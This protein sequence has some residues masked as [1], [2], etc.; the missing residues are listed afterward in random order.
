MRVNQK[1][2]W[3]QILR[4]ALLIQ[5]SLALLTNLTFEIFKKNMAFADTNNPNVAQTCTAE[6]LN[7]FKDAISEISTVATYTTA[8]ES[9]PN[10]TEAAYACDRIQNDSFVASCIIPSTTRVISTQDFAKAC[11]A[12][13][14]LFETKN[15]GEKFKSTPLETGLVND[16]TS[17]VRLE[18]SRISVLVSDSLTL[19]K[20]FDLPLRLSLIEG[21]L[22]EMEDMLATDSLVTCMLDQPKNSQDKFN[23]G[24]VL[25]IDRI[26]QTYVSGFRKA[27]LM[28]ST[29]K[30]SPNGTDKSLTGSIVC[31]TETE[32]GLSFG[33]LKTAFGSI[34][35]VD[36][37]R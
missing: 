2:H 35:A 13:G 4:S 9:I 18:A 10:V 19:Q 37:R 15:G 12:V 1:L 32:Q 28:F 14:H 25:K 30:K 21:K 31:M 36:Y 34:L 24:D 29:V 8:G 33:D 23:N 7:N 11:Q 20:A 22:N 6:A 3:G 16:N 5:I 26:K 27:T 17:I